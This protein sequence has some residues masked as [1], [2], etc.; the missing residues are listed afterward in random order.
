MNQLSWMI[1]NQLG[2]QA[3]GTRPG[4]FLNVKYTLQDQGGHHLGS[5]F[6]IPSFLFIFYY[7]S[8]N[9]WSSLQTAPSLRSGCLI[10]PFP[11]PFCPVGLQLCPFDGMYCCNECGWDL[12]SPPCDYRTQGQHLHFSQYPFPPTSAAV[13]NTSLA[14]LPAC[15][16]LFLGALGSH[17]VSGSLRFLLF[18]CLFVFQRQTLTM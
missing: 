10:S 18:I 14:T 5:F 1:L 2:L 4:S 8:R 16:L 9:M 11:G 7:K 12:N 15:H 6:V 17:L 3:C 13:E